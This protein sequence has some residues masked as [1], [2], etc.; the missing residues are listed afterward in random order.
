M[1]DLS[2]IK[3]IEKALI[4]Y[5]DSPG[6]AWTVKLWACTSISYI[7]FFEILNQQM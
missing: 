5:L 4:S 3:V 7:M 2:V 1:K 6:V